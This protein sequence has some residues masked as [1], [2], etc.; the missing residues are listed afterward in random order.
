M[1]RRRLGRLLAE[2]RP[3]SVPVAPQPADRRAIP[4]IDISKSDRSHIAETLGASFEATGFAVVVGAGERLA[5]ATSGL[6]AAGRSF[7]AQPEELKWK[8]HIDPD[9]MEHPDGN[10]GY[11]EPGHISVAS[12]LGDHSRPPDA[13]ECI[14]FKDL[15]YY[16][17]GCTGP[18]LESKPA[19][20]APKW[21]SEAFRTT[22]LQYFRECHALWQNLVSLAEL[23]LALPAGFFAPYFGQAMSTSLQIRNYLDVETLEAQLPFGAHTDS[24]MFTVVNTQEPGLQVDP[25][26]TGEW[27]DVPTVP[28][29]YVVN[30][31]RCLARWTNDRWLAAVHRVNSSSSNGGPT[32]QTTAFFSFPDLDAT[33]ECLPGCSSKEMPARYLP[34]S[35]REFMEQRV[36]LHT[37][38]E[39]QETIDSNVWDD[40][41]RASKP[42]HPL[43]N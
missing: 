1:R 16:E 39:P 29:G 32:K 43:P 24:G 35:A 13:V 19:K 5:A 8:V 34:F 25:Q 7:F 18:T 42:H 30:V 22:T 37:M 17:S 36:K 23:A 15:H 4:I 6:S 31:G 33:I 27:L 40:P 14:Y 28:G 2:L 21:P 26:L 41:R 3:A 9:L 10:P 38:G 11:L 20:L 12:L